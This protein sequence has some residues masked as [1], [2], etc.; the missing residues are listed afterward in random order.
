MSY[1]VIAR[2]GLARFLECRQC[3]EI[4]IEL[5]RQYDI[6][7]PVRTISKLSQK[8]RRLRSDRS[9]REHQTPQKSD[10]AARWL[11]PAH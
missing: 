5:S 2:V 7:I 11:R 6:E 4:Q 8:I 10:A 3:E 1:D 9:S